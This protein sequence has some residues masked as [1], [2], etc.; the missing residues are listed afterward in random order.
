MRSH[1]DRVSIREVLDPGWEGAREGGRKEGRRET[2]PNKA[3][4]MREE[5][6]HPVE[7]HGPQSM[8]TIV[9]LY[10][11]RHQTPPPPLLCPRD[12]EDGVGAKGISR[13][14]RV[15]VISFGLRPMFGV[16]RRPR[17]S[18]QRDTESP[19]R[20]SLC[21]L[22][23]R[24]STCSPY[25]PCKRRKGICQSDRQFQER[26]IVSSGIAADGRTGGGDSRLVCIVRNIFTY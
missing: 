3:K 2:P 19:T 24:W 5:S 7:R 8:S 10:G 17:E 15:V 14:T 6:I 23:F 16:T 22:L 21:F 11:T 4:E 26:D 9:S 12:C 20:L 1:A 13:R 25:A 18:C